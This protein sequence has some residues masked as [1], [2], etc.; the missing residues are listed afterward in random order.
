M[1]TK[2]FTKEISFSAKTAEK[3]LGAM[4]KSRRVDIE[5]DHEIKQV[6]GETEI[7]K[8]LAKALGK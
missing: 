6:H 3:F 5:S 7:Q 8:L 1:A 2:T 4:N